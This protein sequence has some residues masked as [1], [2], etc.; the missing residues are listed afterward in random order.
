MCGAGNILGVSGKDFRCGEKK[1]RA[2]NRCTYYLHTANWPIFLIY[3]YKSVQSKLIKFKCET[4]SLKN[5]QNY[6]QFFCYIHH[7]GDETGNDDEMILLQ[8]S[9]DSAT[10]DR[11]VLPTNSMVVVHRRLA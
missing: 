11:M 7:G 1:L 8:S 10:T 3:E 5:E 4:I 2:K 6:R 9:F